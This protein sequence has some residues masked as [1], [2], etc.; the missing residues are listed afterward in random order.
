[1]GIPLQLQLIPVISR[2][3]S[4]SM[5]LIYLVL[6]IAVDIRNLHQLYM[7][8]ENSTASAFLARPTQ[9]EQS[10]FSILIQPPIGLKQLTIVTMC[11]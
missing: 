10:K 11:L 8:M 4:T 6:T 5:L 3:R 1:V 2:K 7:V 9:T